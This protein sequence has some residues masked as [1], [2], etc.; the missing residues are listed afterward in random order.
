MTALV[1]GV[2]HALLM[3]CDEGIVRFAWAGPVPSCRCG[4]SLTETGEA[5]TKRV[6]AMA[7]KWAGEWVLECQFCGVFVDVR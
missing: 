7:G 1:S 4:A 5:D 6:R 2:S 3:D